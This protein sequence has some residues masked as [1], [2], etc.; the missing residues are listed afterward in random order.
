MGKI[1]LA[2]THGD[3]NGIS[4]EIIIKTLRDNR[5]LDFCTP[6]IYGSP[7]VA[8]YHRKAI[9]AGHFSM[10]HINSV[11]QARDKKVNIINCIDDNIRVELGKSSEAAGEASYLALE[12]AVTDLRQGLADV[13]VT[14]PINKHNIQR[15]SFNFSGHTEYLAEKFESEKHIM[16]MLSDNMKV[17]V[18]TG[19]LPIKEVA[20]N[21]TKE[22]IIEKIEVLEQSLVYD[23]GISNPKIAVLGLNPHIGDSGLIGEEEEEIII[24]A[25][26]EVREKKI[27]ALGPYPAD[28]FFGSAAYEKF[29]AV[30]AMYHDQGLAPFKALSRDGGVNYT[31]GLPV[32]RT[33]P[34]HGTAYELAGQGV[35]SPD[36][37]RK[38]LYI[39]IDIFRSRNKEAEYEKDAL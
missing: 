10:N 14:A 33:S 29:D 26:N 35:A 23:F 31:A 2:I 22:N 32:V 25:I 1:K 7:K 5:I 11:D 21:I 38:A 34:D 4:Y 6:I 17:G 37:F 20:Q 9:N 12:A 30:L 13:L 15:D 8:A 3:I 27:T 19:H 39:A 24:P 36:A 18:V 28:G 16:L